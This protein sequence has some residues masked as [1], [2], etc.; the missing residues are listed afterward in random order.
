MVT[1]LILTS[2]LAA[3]V[4][5]SARLLVGEGQ[6]FE[7]LA[8]WLAGHHKQL[9]KPLLN[10]IFC[11]GTTYVPI[12]WGLLLHILSLPIDSQTLAVLFL[13]WVAS[14][15]VNSTVLIFSKSLKDHRLPSTF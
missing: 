10:C 7:K 2:L 6:V 12:T 3:L 9:G 1:L 5:S 14:P 11:M 8:G 4:A 13:T 15:Y